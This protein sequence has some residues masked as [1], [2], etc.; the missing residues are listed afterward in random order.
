[1]DIDGAFLVASWMKEAEDG[2]GCRLLFARSGGGEG[3]TKSGRYGGGAE[4]VYDVDIEQNL[5]SSTYRERRRQFSL[6]RWLCWI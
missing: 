5:G 3:K 6:T 4:L 1:M 2:S